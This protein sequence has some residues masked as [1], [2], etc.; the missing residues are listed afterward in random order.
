MKGVG[1]LWVATAVWMTRAVKTARGVADMVFRQ[2]KEGREN[3]EYVMMRPLKPE[4]IADDKAEDL[5]RRFTGCYS[6]VGINVK[7]WEIGGK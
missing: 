3:V 7:I 1:R 2:P 5:K 4:R 6:D